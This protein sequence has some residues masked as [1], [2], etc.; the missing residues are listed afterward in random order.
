MGVK[1][2]AS[3]PA[4]PLFILTR[5][6]G[7]SRNPEDPCNERHPAKAIAPLVIPAEA[8][9]HGP[10]SWASPLPEHPTTSPVIPAESGNPRP[11]TPRQVHSPEHP[12]TSPVI[13][14]QSLPRTTIRRP[15]PTARTP[16]QVH[17]PEH[18]TTSPVIPAEAGTHGPDSWASPLPR[19]PNH[20]TRHSRGELAPDHDPG[21]EPTARTPRQVHSPEHPTTSPVIPAE[22][23]PRTRS[24]AGTHGPDS[25][26]SPLPRTPNHLTRH[27]RGE[28]APDHDPGREPTARTPRQVHSPEHPTTSPVI[29]AKAGT[30]GPDSWASPLPRTPNHLTRHSRGGGNPRPALL[31]KSTPPKTAPPH[32]SFPRRRE[33]TARTLV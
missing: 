4:H 17:S 14:A 1:D 32:L 10:D 5:H 18:P 6:S 23:L 24:G 16:R 8:G 15:E 22:S 21:R 7:E 13:P 20:L 9:T 33:P 27:S 29:P 2:P 31:G 28:L 30:H 19:T 12:T 25:W 3:S 11:T 26:A